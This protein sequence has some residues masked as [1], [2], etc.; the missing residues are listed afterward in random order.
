MIHNNSS[1]NVFLK[2]IMDVN[3]KVTLMSAT[4][5]MCLR[6]E[7]KITSKTLRKLAFERPVI[8]FK[9]LFQLA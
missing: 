1:L 7:N 6:K 5:Y 4:I 2:K 3:D 8:Y 9:K